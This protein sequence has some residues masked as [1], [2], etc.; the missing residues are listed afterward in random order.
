MKEN[1]VIE[2][3][4]KQFRA[5]VIAD[6]KK[7]NPSKLCID[8][9]R[10]YSSGHCAEFAYSLAKYAAVSLGISSK[11]VI[12]YALEKD[13]ETNTIKNKTLSHCIVEIGK[14]NYD[15]SGNEARASW[16]TKHNYIYDNNYASHFEWEFESI[17]FTDQDAVYM[18]LQKHCAGHRVPLSKS[19]IEKDFMILKATNFGNESCVER[20]SHYEP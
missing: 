2:S 10:Y 12:M 5:R 19:Q 9:Y 7:N 3:A 20:E 4:L 6:D 18:E 8:P 14:E 17:P 15:I 11:I 16:F 1:E 13:N